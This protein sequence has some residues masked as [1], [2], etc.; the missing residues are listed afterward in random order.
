M[1]HRKEVDF[2]WCKT[3]RYWKLN[4]TESPCDE[5]LFISIN[6]LLK[7]MELLREDSHKPYYYEEEK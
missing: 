5:C 1:E 2:T 7:T 6:M 4:T 3:C